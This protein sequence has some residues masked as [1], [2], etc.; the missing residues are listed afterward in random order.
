MQINLIQFASKQRSKFRF[1]LF[2]RLFQSLACF[3]CLLACKTLNWLQLKRALFCTSVCI[4]QLSFIHSF[5]DEIAHLFALALRNTK[6]L[7]NRCSK[8]ASI[9]AES[10]EH[11]V[12]I[13]AKVLQADLNFKPNLRYQSKHKNARF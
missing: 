4:L 8:K 12:C 1:A 6:Q 9:A 5:I 10:S 13:V 11:K 2:A 7:R 3:A